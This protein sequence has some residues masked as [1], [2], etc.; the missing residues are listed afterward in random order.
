MNR[1][2]K[3]QDALFFVQEQGVKVVPS[4]V[5]LDWTYQTPWPRP[6]YEEEL[7]AVC[8]WYGAILIKIGYRRTQTE[9]RDGVNKYLGVD[10]SWVHRFSAGFNGGH[11][12][13]IKT[14]KGKMVNEPISTIG[15]QF[16]KKLLRPS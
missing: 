2:Q 8:N 11:Q 13:K 16:R 12:L 14:E 9:Q 15:L 7:P 4:Y 3:I 5:M 6:R 10:N 1:Q